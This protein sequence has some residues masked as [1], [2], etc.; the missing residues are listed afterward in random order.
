M[1]LYLPIS[2][3]FGISLEWRTLLLVP[4]FAMA[5]AELLQLRQLRWLAV[6]MA[7]LAL[8]YVSNPSK[9]DVIHNKPYI[10]NQSSQN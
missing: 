2:S 10:E 4:F 3:V 5:A 7:V 1:V 9:T 6:A 8:I